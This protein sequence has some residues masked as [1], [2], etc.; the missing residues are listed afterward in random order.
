MISLR[1]TRPVPRRDDCTSGRLRVAPRECGVLRVLTQGTAGTLTG[2]RRSDEN[3]TFWMR[4]E[5]VLT[6]FMTIEVCR[7]YS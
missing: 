4:L 6:Y 1:P 5:D 2:M 3:S 7:C